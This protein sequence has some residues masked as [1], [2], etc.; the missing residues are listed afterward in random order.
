MK[1]IIIAKEPYEIKTLD[2]VTNIAYVDN[3]YIIT[4]SNVNYSYDK[5]KYSL[6]II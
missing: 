2:N 3:K 5:A 6:M 4:S 1:V